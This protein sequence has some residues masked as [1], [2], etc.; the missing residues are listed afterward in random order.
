MSGLE[1]RVAVVTGAARGIGRAT[2]VELARQG[3]DV[4]AVDVAAPIEGNP[5]SMG[6]PEELEETVALVEKEG[7]RAQAVEADVRDAA[8]MEGA[9]RSAV[10]GFGSLDI[11][12][13]NAALTVHNPFAKM[14][15]DQWELVLGVNL[16]GIVK[17]V[18]AALPYMV[19]RGYGRVITLSSVGG[20]GGLPGGPAYGASKMAIISVTKTIAL[21]HA[22]DGITANVVAPGVVDTPL[23]RSDEQYR[24]NR[25]DLYERATTFEEREAEMNRWVRDA[26]HVIPVGWMP[27]QAIADAIAFLASD[28]ARYIT[29]EVMDVAAGVNARHMA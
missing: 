14:T 9:M 12:V 15:D 29:G 22:A 28:R 1:G 17:T 19:E 26:F 25:P 2:S 27:P 10:E 16:M 6:T 5:Q 3:A 18:R 4:V 7:R 23:F 13:A 20:R 24:D 21:E 11:V 8:A